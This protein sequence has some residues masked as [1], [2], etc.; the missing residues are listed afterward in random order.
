MSCCNDCALHDRPYGDLVARDIRSETT[1]S[2]DPIISAHAIHWVLTGEA[3]SNNRRPEIEGWVYVPEYSNPDVATYR[4]NEHTIV[5]FRGTVN[6]TDVRSDMQLSVPGANSCAFDKVKPSVELIQRYIGT[7]QSLVQTT[8]HSLGGAIARCVGNQLGL[9]VVTFNAAAPPSNPVKAGP[10]EV[11]YHI[12]F[13]VIS[14][15]TSPSTVRIDKGYAPHRLLKI[16]LVGKY[17]NR[18]FLRI[19]I[20]TLLNAHSLTNF[21]AERSGKIITTKQEEN[22][23]INWFIHLPP[24]FKLTFL[25]FV[26]APELPPLS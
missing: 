24:L 15:W 4:N 5:A 21:S 7:T 13:D 10:N 18:W 19:G 2:A 8:G 17:L 16:P 25:A 6:L 1:S 9:G 14:A 11:D 12:A 22:I 26:Q 3:Y 23:W 20:K